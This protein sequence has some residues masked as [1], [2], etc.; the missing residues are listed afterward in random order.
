MIPFTILEPPVFTVNQ[1]NGKKY[2]RN[3][4]KDNLLMDGANSETS[5]VRRL[6]EIN[7]AP[8]TS[9]A[10]KGLDCQISLIPSSYLGMYF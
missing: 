3:I 7:K 9:A 5:R 8:E 10:C 1:H 6:P 2:E 4:L